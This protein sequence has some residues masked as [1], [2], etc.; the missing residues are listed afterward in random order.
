MSA[1]WK[2]THLRKWK[3]SRL[4]LGGVCRLGPRLYVMKGVRATVQGLLEAIS[5]MAKH[6]K[7]G[8]IYLAETDFVDVCSVTDGRELQRPGGDPLRIVNMPALPKGVVLIQAQRAE[9]RGI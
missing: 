5:A 9:K 1:G 4:L 8:V 3:N 7:P 2:N 6:Q